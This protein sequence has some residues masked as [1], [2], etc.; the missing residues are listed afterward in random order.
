MQVDIYSSGLGGMVLSQDT[1]LH[2]YA[3]VFIDGAAKG[4]PLNAAKIQQL[5]QTTR[6]V[7]VNPQAGLQGNVPLARHPDIPAGRCS[8][9]TSGYRPKRS[10]LSTASS[11]KSFLSHL[12]EV[13]A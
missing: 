4:L 2:A 11:S 9:R 5:A 3:L 8:R 1:D 6:L 12:S 7:V 13:Q 10:V